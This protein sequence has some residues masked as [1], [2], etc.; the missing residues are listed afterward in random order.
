MAEPVMFA[1]G[2]TKGF[3]MQQA[4][5]NSIEVPIRVCSSHN[6]ME[7][8]FTTVRQSHFSSRLPGDSVCWEPHFA[9]SAL[10]VLSI[11]LSSI[12]VGPPSGDGEQRLVVRFVQPQNEATVDRFLQDLAISLSVSIAS[13]Q[14]DAYYG[15]LFVEISLA[16]VKHIRSSS[17]GGL[18]L[19][20]AITMESTNPQ[21]LSAKILEGLKS[22]P[23]AEIFVDG[24]RAPDAKSKFIHWFV[25]VEELER[26]SEFDP[27]FERLFSSDQIH[28]VVSSGRLTVV[29]VDRFKGWANGRNLTLQ[30]RVEKLRMIFEEIGIT[31]LK[32]ING[33]VAVT[34]ELLKSLVE[35]R[36][37]VAHRG[38]K[39]DV[40]AVYTVLF[41]LSREALAYLMKRDQAV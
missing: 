37:K 19:T 13:R 17:A 16:E 28:A 9:A 11:E 34:T 12:D 23:L 3:H 4:D 1:A 2:P 29:Q 18:Y 35:Q 39:I 8:G 5:I 15:V 32:T 10:I 26:C 30:G 36:N 33:P 21:P 25:M 31:T 38:S 40:T 27:L 24:M 14:L 7:R 6:V 20:E 22:S 41:A